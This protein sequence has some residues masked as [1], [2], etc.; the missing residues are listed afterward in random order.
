MWQLKYFI[1]TQWEE[2]LLDD[3]EQ[4]KVVMHSICQAFVTVWGIRVV[5]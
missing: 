3:F 1:D 5:Y 2:N 4:E